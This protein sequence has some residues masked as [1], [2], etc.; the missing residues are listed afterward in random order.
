MPDIPVGSWAESV[1]N[2]LREYF[3]PIFDAISHVML[4][5]IDIVLAALTAPHPLVITALAVALA[6]WERGVGLAVFSLAGM[7]LLQSMGLWDESM[8]SLAIVL[9]ASL[10]A[11]A[12][13]I[14][15]G[16]L[17]AKNRHA[18]SILR[19][20]LDAMQTL[21]AFVYLIPAVFFFGIGVVPAVVA[22]FIFAIPPAVRLTELGIRQVDPEMVE[23]SAAF[24]AGPMQA[25]RQVQLPLAIPSI[26][27]G[28]NQVIMMSLSMVVIAGLVGAGGLGS[29][30]VTGISRLDIGT[31][32]EG[33]IAV[34]FLAMYLDRVTGAFPRARK[35]PN[36]PREAAAV[37]E[38]EIA[39][40]PVLSKTA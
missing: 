14:P 38:P 17:A 23:A 39:T 22:T 30:V 8:Q 16:V 19:P 18:S 1:V 27:T 10:L 15:G 35:Q 26:M 37:S 9:V 7:L 4:W 6:W 11:I 40:A 29:T 28:V 21:P 31:G 36:K 12:V 24:G 13:G 32:F 33:G 2:W 5:L 25:L 3:T 34:V 20:A